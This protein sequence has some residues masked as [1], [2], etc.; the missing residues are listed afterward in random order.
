LKIAL[1]ELQHAE[2]RWDVGR[3]C[4]AQLL[5]V[6]PIQKL[7]Q[8]ANALVP[9]LPGGFPLQADLK[10]K[11]NRPPITKVNDLELV[12]LDRRRI[13]RPKGKEADYRA[14]EQTSEDH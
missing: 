14:G 3:F 2:R 10:P 11:K 9:Y 7:E 1:N 6:V 5:I 12:A 8:L 4:L 13:I